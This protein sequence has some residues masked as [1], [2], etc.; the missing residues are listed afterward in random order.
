MEACSACHKTLRRAE[1][2]ERG[3]GPVCWGRAMAKVDEEETDEN[4]IIG[5]FAGDVVL[6]RSEKNVIGTNV[7][8]IVIQHSPA[9]Y[10]WGYGGSGPSDL[11]LNILNL[12][13]PPGSDGE[14]PVKCHEGQCSETAWRL[15][16][17]F[18]RRFIAA[19]PHE[20]MTIKGKDIAEW[21]RGHG[22]PRA[23]LEKTILRKT[24]QLTLEGNND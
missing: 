24:R 15:H 17:D 20:G 18:K 9:G 5:G 2:I 4:V 8:H 10:E 3:M 11:A 7:P 19:V 23:L 1:S 22:V 16:H 12:I 21:L 6:V 13:V 14:P